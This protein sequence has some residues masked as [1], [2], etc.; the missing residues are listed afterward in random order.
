MAKQVGRLKQYLTLPCLAFLLSLGAL[1]SDANEAKDSGENRPMKVIMPLWGPSI[2]ADGTGM[3]V[4]LFRFVL[5]GHEH[6]YEIEYV[7]YDKALRLLLY[8]D[9]DCA[10]PVSKPTILVS[11]KHVDAA[12]LIQSQPVLVSKTYVFSRP[13]E[14]VFST[15]EALKGKLLIQIRGENY[16]HNF[17]TVRARFWNVDSEPEKVRVLLGGRGDA[18]LGSMPD[19]LITFAEMGVEIPPYDPDFSVLDYDNA[20]TCR[21]S[22]EA[23]ALV[24]LFNRRIRETVED[25]SL[26]AHAVDNGVPE[27][28]VDAFLPTLSR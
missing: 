3:F 25:G 28:V 24:D 10:Y 8:S 4:D 16:N 7:S 1:A 13:G 12:Q 17:T 27:L 19:I 22:A 9:V 6:R 18:M 2:Q 5:K 26:R 14:P 23:A 15:M 11:M 21:N 20:M